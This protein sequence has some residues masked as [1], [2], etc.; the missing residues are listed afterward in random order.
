MATIQKRKNGDG[1]T[2]FLTWVRIKGFKP[3]TRS[4]ETRAAAKAWATKHEAELREQRKRVTARPDISSLTVASLVKEYLADPEVQAL[5]THDSY[6]RQLGW[7]VDHYGTERMESFGVFQQREARAKLMPGRANA[8]VDRYLS[9]MRGAFNWGKSAGLILDNRSWPTGLMLTE[10]KGRTRFLDDRELKA[11]LDAAQAHSA[12]MHAA[13]IV[14][15]ATGLRQG[16]LL[17]LTWKDID[18]DKKHLR[19]LQSKNDEARVVHVPDFA[20]E[21]LRAL[22]RADVVSPRYVFLAENGKPLTQNLLGHRWKVIRKA[23]GLQDFRWH[24]LRH[25]CASY[26][27]QNGATLLE[28]GSVLGHKSP[29][30]TMRYAHLLAGA[31]VKGHSELDEKLRTSSK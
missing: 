8:T 1:S 3:V 13:I 7:W 17:R 30:V 23:A 25:S 16:E 19:V 11:V 15:I 14:S 18:L 9:A 5:R 26:L 4:F 20:V 6:E 21:A 12:A 2:A 24:D 27:A 10:P 28:I 22:K 29:S 31:A